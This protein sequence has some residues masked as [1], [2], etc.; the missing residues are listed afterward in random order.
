MHISRTRNLIEKFKNT[1]LGR[2]FTITLVL[3]LILPLVLVFS[4]MNSVIAKKFLEK[5]YEK[6]LEILK[7]SRPSLENLLEDTQ[8]LSRNLVGDKE[9]QSLLEEYDKYGTINEENLRKL[10]INI[11]QSIYTKKYI[12]SLSLYVGDKILYQYGNYYKGEDILNLSSKAQKLEMLRGKPMWDPARVLGGYV[13][14]K[15]NTAVVS[16]YRIINHLYRL[17]PLGAERISI[18]EEYLCSL[19]ASVENQNGDEAYIFDEDGK[20]GRAHV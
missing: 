9:I 13:T 17:V 4:V 3:L 10:K 7:Q 12:S 18:D 2:K 20:I 15:G 16:V 8:M 14:G 5:Q 11:E 19:Y 1:G 6:E